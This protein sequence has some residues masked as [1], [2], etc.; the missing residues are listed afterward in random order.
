MAVTESELEKYLVQVR[1][2]AEHRENGAERKIKQIYKNLTEDLNSWLGNCYAKYAEDDKLDFAVLRQKGQYARFLEEVQLKVD[3]IYPELK[4]TVEELIDTTYKVCWHGMYD[5]VTKSKKVED[6]HKAF[7]ASKAITPEQIKAAVQNPIPKL[8]LKPILERN[9][10]QIIGDIRR[11][12]GVGLSN[13]DRMST[14]A[15]RI[16]KYVDGDYN[17]S[18]RIARTEAHRVREVGFNDSAERIDRIMQD[19]NSDCRMVKIWRNK[20]DLAVRKT[21]KANHVDMEGQTVLADEEFT[22]ISG[23]KAKCPGTS[24]V[25]AEDCNCR[26]RASRDIMNDAEFYAATGRHFPG[27]AAQTTKTPNN[28]NNTLQNQQKSDKIEKSEIRKELEKSG[29]AYNDVALLPKTLSSSEIVTRLGG[30]DMTSGSCSSLGFA[31][32]GNKQ[33]YDV[34]DFR[35]GNSQHF[36]ARNNNIKQMLN[37]PGV[38]GS[39]TKVEKEAGDTAKIIKGLEYEKEYYIAVGRHAAIIRNTEHGAEYLELQSPKSNGWQTFDKYGSTIATLRKRFGCRKTAD[40]MR[41]GNR[42]VVFE[43]EVVLMEVDSFKNNDEFRRILGYINTAL[44]EQKKGAMG[45][46]K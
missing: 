38:K 30:G 39:I 27:Y 20:K 41:I 14:M 10:R 42:S 17:K 35:G 18:M 37:L 26:C 19:N 1:R 4:N 13:G 22:L 34:L 8:R 43:K 46:V 40:R 6:L 24:G 31:Y 5:G 44:N 33:G 15:R 11:E 45:S 9:R 36:F 12:I 32:I 21:D 23:A 3:R 25:A 2:I 16:S 7:K 28:L 29:I